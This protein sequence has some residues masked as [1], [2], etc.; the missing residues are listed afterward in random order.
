MGFSLAE[1]EVYSWG[2][3]ARGR[4]GRRDEEAGFPRPVQLDEIHPYTVTS[5]SCCH[6]NTLLAVRRESELSCLTHP[7][8]GYFSWP[9]PH[10][11]PLATT[12][13]TNSIFNIQS[14]GVQKAVLGV[15]T[16]YRPVSPV[17]WTQYLFFGGSYLAILRAYSWL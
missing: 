9:N 15:G 7:G 16:S 11:Q 13:I 1:G 10:A 3:G 2:K 5:V 6:G 12:Q 4:L 17:P 14:S 8:W